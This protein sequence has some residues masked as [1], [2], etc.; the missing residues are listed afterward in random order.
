MDVLTDG[1]RSSSRFFVVVDAWMD[2]VMDVV[3]DDAW[4]DGVM[5]GLSRGSKMLSFSSFASPR[6]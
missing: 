6:F 3:M 4:L 1:G 2:V 5:R